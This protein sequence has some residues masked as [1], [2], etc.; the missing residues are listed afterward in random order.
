[1]HACIMQHCMM[2]PKHAARLGSLPAFPAG[3]RTRSLT[4][5][6]LMSEPYDASPDGALL[7]ARGR[8]RDWSPPRSAPHTVMTIF[9]WACP[10]PMYRR[11]LA[12]SLNS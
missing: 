3:A 5:E 12:I 2:R 7:K 6:E 10:S 1:M 11:A 4:G 9:P 8:L